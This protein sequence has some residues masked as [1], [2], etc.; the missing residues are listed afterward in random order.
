MIISQINFISKN[1]IATYAKHAKVTQSNNWLLSSLEYKLVN[2][3]LII[4]KST[5][6]FLTVFEHSEQASPIS[7]GVVEIWINIHLAREITW[8]HD[9]RKPWRHHEWPPF[10]L[11][12]KESGWV[13][14]HPIACLSCYNLVGP[15]WVAHTLSQCTSVREVRHRPTRWPSKL[16]SLQDPI[17]PVCAN[18]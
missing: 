5:M 8:Q 10:A 6:R 1:R 11:T 12:I 2:V 7:E 16:L 17:N 4:L 14:P 3:I 18:T 15:P 9:T 13:L